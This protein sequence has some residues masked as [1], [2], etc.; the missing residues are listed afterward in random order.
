MNMCAWYLRGKR[1]YI[2]RF[3]K[4]AICTISNLLLHCSALR[5][6]LLSV[7]FQRVFVARTEFDAVVDQYIQKHHEPKRAKL[8]ITQTC[9]TKP[10]KYSVVLSDKKTRH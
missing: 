3:Y 4:Y 10:F 2:P 7:V 8:F 5:T 6:L 9:T 1:N